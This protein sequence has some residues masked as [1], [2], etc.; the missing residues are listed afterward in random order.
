MAGKHDEV[1]TVMAIPEIVGHVDSAAIIGQL[2]SSCGEDWTFK[3]VRAESLPTDK[4]DRLLLLQ[5]DGT[6][7]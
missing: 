5:T 6:T 7:H 4:V 3:T 1:K 2:Q